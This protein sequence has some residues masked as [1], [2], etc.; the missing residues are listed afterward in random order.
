[1]N[2]LIFDLDG[3]LIDSSESILMALK[4]ACE[5]CEVRP[6]VPLGKNLVGPPL[7]EML[8][9]I[10]GSKEAKTISC[11]R[12]KFIQYYDTEACT[13]ARPFPGIES[14]LASANDLGLNLALATNKR[15]E[16]TK[17][18]LE[19]KEWNRFFKQVETIDSGSEKQQSKTQM[20]K[21]VLSGFPKESAALYVGDTEGDYLSAREAG[22]SCVIVEWGY[23]KPDFD[24]DVPLAQL[25]NDILDYLETMTSSF[26]PE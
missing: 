26:K 6:V 11:L 20:I 16:P 21:N 4:K 5:L 24:V 2:L 18:I 22:I 19:S 15:F 13:L 3:T 8:K 10:S 12:S 23:R 1:M 17:K 25:P 9:L 14:M 7:D